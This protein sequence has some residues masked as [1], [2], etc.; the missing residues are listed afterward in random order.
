NHLIST[1]IGAAGLDLSSAASAALAGRSMI[2]RKA[3]VV[4][5]ECV[6]RG[7]LAGSGWREYRAGGKVCG[8][9][10]PAGLVESDRI[11]TLFTP[12]TK[13]TSGHDENIPFARMAAALGAD[14]AEL[15][16]SSS[17]AIYE[18]AGE[19]AAAHGLI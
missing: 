16:A 7:Y 19:Y 10:L 8:I 6:V 14:T 4:A 1:E 12:A 17:V 13:A 15:L 3:D 5:F 9:D 2:V 18:K 11:P